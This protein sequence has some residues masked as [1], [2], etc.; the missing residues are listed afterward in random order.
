[1]NITC[2]NKHKDMVETPEENLH[3]RQTEMDPGRVTIHSHWPTY[4]LICIFIQM[5]VQCNS[6]LMLRDFDFP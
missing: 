3:C 2:S 4:V 1:M 5:M 6:Q